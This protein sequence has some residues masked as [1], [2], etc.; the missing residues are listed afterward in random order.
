MTMTTPL[1]DGGI[2]T[3]V[4][5]AD[6]TTI[7]MTET[8][9][10]VRTG[11]C[12][13]ADGRE[14]VLPDKFF[15][16]PIPTMADGALSALEV[17]AGQ[18]I[19]G[20]TSAELDKIKTGAKF[21]GPA[22]GL[23]TMAYGIVSADTLHDACVAGISGTYSAIGGIAVAGVG[24]AAAGPLGAFGGSLLGSWT[25]GYVGAVVGEVLC[26]K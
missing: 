16:D 12:I 19:P 18:G 8:A 20:L 17:K 6:G 1:E 21:G 22:I 11:S 2:K 23:A 26:P 9:D 10:G 15:T 14:T 5:W 7:T 25:F 3:N 24:G 13:T 4:S